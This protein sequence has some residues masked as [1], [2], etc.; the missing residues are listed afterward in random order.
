MQELGASVESPGTLPCAVVAVSKEWVDQEHRPLSSSLKPRTL[1]PTVQ[2]SSFP[3]PP[4]PQSPESSPRLKPSAVL[5]FHKLGP[6]PANPRGV[7]LP[8]AFHEENVL[9]VLSVLSAVISSA[10]D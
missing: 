5:S 10:L 8:A 4:P 3:P 1:R 9:G 6:C 2:W 7:R